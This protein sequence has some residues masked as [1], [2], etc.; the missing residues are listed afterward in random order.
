MSSN[1]ASTIALQTHG[2]GKNYGRAAA[3]SDV[4]LTVRVGDIYGLVGRNGAGKTTLFKAVMGL[5]RPSHGSITLF[6]SG[7][8]NRQRHHVGF[9]IAPTAYPYLSAAQNLTYLAQVK[10]IA[11][12]GEVNRVLELVG[13][14]G[15]RKPFKAF[16]MG[17]KQRLG[18]GAALLGNPAL[19]V[20][21]EP[22]NGLDPTGI[23]DIR[24]I[25]QHSNQERG[26]TF[27]ISSHI[28]SELDMVATRF[29]ILEQGRL[30]EESTRE[31]LH[32]KSGS[33][34]QYYMSLIMGGGQ[35]D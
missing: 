2:L 19:V 3:L 31:E 13:L 35:R 25:I 1:C 23:A 24:R 7:D 30:L 9:M 8:L 17:M 10:G 4:S 21:D 14:A 15:V 5:A 20:L 16:S 29:G 11:D 26:T 18:I 27:I 34:E 22:I 12:K 28:L 33:L 32:A 6:S